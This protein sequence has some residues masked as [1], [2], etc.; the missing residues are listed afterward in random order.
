MQDR[1]AQAV[2]AELEARKAAWRV[3]SEAFKSPKVHIDQAT[4]LSH[5]PEGDTLRRCEY[6]LKQLRYGEWT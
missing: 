5:L 3:L 6:E 4:I 1:I 2:K